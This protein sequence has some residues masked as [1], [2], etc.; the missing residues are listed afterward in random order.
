MSTPPDEDGTEPGRRA[1]LV[2]ADP[3]RGFCEQLARQVTEPLRKMAG[4]LSLQITSHF[5]R[6]VTRQHRRSIRKI[7]R[8]VTKPIGVA[9]E[10]RFE[11]PFSDRELR[12]EAEII[13]EVK[14]RC[15]K[16]GDQVAALRRCRL[17]VRPASRIW[18]VRLPGQQNYVF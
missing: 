14:L 3:F 9:V 2:P 8:Q 17:K 7:G 12:E 11:R 15:P 18:V 5:T 1:P 6:E 4:E 13:S 16:C 10:K